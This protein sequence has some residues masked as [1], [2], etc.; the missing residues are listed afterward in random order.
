MLQKKLKHIKAKLKSWNKKEFGNIFKAKKVVE[1]K[2]HGVNV[3]LITDGF[4]VESKIQDNSLQQEWE[5]L[6]KQE[7]IF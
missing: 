2:L 4:T 6:C 5:G 3:V 1:R 7:E